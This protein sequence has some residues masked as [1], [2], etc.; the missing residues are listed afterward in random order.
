M[1][2]ISGAAILPDFLLS[3]KAAGA[4]PR[5][6]EMSQ[7]GP[8][9]MVTA[10]D[11]TENQIISEA[12]TVGMDRDVELATLKS[13][14]ER[15][16]RRA[17]IEGARNGHLACKT[18]RSDGFAAFPKLIPGALEHA[19][20]NAYMEAVERYAWAR[21]WDE[22]DLKYGSRVVGRRF[23]SEGQGMLAHL[24]KLVPLRECYAVTPQLADSDVY[25]VMYFAFVN[26][27]GVVSG[28]ACSSREEVRL[29]QFRAMCELARHALAVHRMAEKNLKP[30]TFYEQRL[31]F[32]G[33]EA[34]GENLVR[35][36]LEHKGTSSITLPELEI[37][38]VI[39]HTFDNLVAVH[40]C[41]FENQ[42][43]FV[44]GDLERLCL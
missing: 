37:D 30:E 14:V 35:Q 29:A 43:P 3:L 38:E 31:A 10:F 40:R 26:K 7:I 24:S 1:T 25:V 6:M 13:L 19:R 44:G 20:K 41:L 18:E 33:L 39:P 15:L 36:R 22:P 21:W 11:S 12:A 17:F 8:V 32:F 42:P 34:S 28:G 9:H 2:E 27:V 5:K 4:L 16:E 23:G